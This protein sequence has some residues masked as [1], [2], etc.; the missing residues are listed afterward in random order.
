MKEWKPSKETLKIFG[1]IE[2]RINEI[3]NKGIDEKKYGSLN[4]A[5]K[6]AFKIG[7]LVDIDD[8]V[9][10]LKRDFKLFRNSSDRE[11][12]I[13]IL[14]KENQKLK[15]KILGL[16]GENKELTEQNTQLLVKLKE[17]K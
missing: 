12:M 15:K 6:V 17:S 11:N 5:Y 9:I 13:N 2:H 16:E 1:A 4:P 3:W 14:A 7:I 8:V 10:K